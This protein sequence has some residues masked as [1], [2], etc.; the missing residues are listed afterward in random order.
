MKR[1]ASVWILFVLIILVIVLTVLVI[2]NILPE[3][4]LFT[5]A[6]YYLIKNF[7]NDKTNFVNQNKEGK[8]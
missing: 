6:I 1:K 2:Y 4:L 3:W 7:L 5:I 8:L